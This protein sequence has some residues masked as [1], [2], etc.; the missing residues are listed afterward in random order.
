[1][2]H[3]TARRMRWLLTFLVLRSSFALF[4]DVQATGVAPEP[5]LRL[6][7]SPELIGPPLAA[8][9]QGA[10]QPI[11]L[12]W[13]SVKELAEGE[14]YEV[15]VDYWYRETHPLLYFTTQQTQVTLPETLYRSP[16]CGVFNWRVTLKRQTGLRDDGQPKGEP[17][18]HQSL[19]GYFWWQYPPGEERDFPPLC[20]YTHLD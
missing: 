11:I 14:Y 3:S 12:Q 7:P 2:F 4:P 18:S 1:M 19:Y 9:F 6:L 10:E 8:R 5:L 17:I 13:K 20:P 15:V 16:N